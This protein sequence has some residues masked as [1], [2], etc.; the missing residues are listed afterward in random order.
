MRNLSE[1][2]LVLLLILTCFT[3]VEGICISSDTSLYEE[4]G[5][6]ETRLI[7]FVIKSG[8]VETRLIGSV[9]ELGV[10]CSLFIEGEKTAAPS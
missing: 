3:R 5:V 2:I 4:L 10:T 7:G 9:I 8:V 6:V 1:I